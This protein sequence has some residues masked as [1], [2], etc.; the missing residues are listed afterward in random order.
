MQKKYLTVVEAAEYLNM[1]DR[2]VRRLVSE[3]RIPFHKVGA[4]IRLA[5]ADLDE[6]MRAAR[7]EPI[8]RADVVSAWREVA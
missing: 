5:I 7:V 6:F 8:A 3:R 2:F 4:S 1:S